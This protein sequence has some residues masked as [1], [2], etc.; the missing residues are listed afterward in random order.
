V[1]LVLAGAPVARADRVLIRQA[2]VNL[3]DKAIKY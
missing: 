2:G 3:I 1:A